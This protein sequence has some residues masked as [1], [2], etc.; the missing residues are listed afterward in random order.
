MRTR[1]QY[2][3]AGID[4]WSIRIQVLILVLLLASS[5]AVAGHENAPPII[6][7]HSGA[8]SPTWR[9]LVNFTSSMQPMDCYCGIHCKDQKVLLI[10]ANVGFRLTCFGT[11]HT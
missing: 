6:H 1:Q 5:M 2:R 9:V 4:F 3:G 11:T 8:M 7:L 10:G